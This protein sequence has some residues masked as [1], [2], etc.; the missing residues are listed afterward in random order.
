MM[1]KL[2]SLAPLVR[3]EDTRTVKPPPS[4]PTFAQRFK[5]RDP[6]YATPEFRAWRAKVIA[7]AG[8][9]CEAITHGYRCTKA[10]PAHRMF[11]D[12]RIELSDGGAPFDIS[13]GQCLCGPHHL[14]KTAQA[15]R[16]RLARN[17]AGGQNGGDAPQ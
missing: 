16:D 7:R 4:R 10:Q 5:A 9:R 11:A 8:G 15:R 14:M 17:R 2:R 13:N 3:I 1:P 6:F 12:H